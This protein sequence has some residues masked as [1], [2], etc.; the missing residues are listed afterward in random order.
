[1]KTVKVVCI[2][3]LRSMIVSIAELLLLYRK[4]KNLLLCTHISVFVDSKRLFNKCQALIFCFIL[5]NETYIWW[6][7]AHAYSSQHLLWKEKPTIHNMI[8]FNLMHCV[9]FD[10]F[11]QFRG[12]LRCTDCK[13]LRTSDFFWNYA[14]YFYRQ[15]I[16]WFIA[17]LLTC[18]CVYFICWK[19]VLK[20][21]ELNG[22]NLRESYF[23][24]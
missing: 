2:C 19:S 11:K 7:Q 20:T 13:I 14:I 23:R 4:F 18:S 6:K 24:L 12:V 8:S 15:I 21:V 10:L 9:L 16:K 5:L 3:L 17:L 1:M 22:Y